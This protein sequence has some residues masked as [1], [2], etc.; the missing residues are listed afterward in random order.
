VSLSESELLI[1]SYAKTLKYN[2]NTKTY[3]L[4]YQHEIN[5]QQFSLTADISR[6]S[7]R[8]HNVCMFAA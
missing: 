6:L 1:Q 2:N 4:N 8:D 3:H 5:N 7:R